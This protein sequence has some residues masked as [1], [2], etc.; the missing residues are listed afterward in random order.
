MPG[1]IVA[2]HNAEGRL[3]LAVCDADI[4][5]KK[6]ESGD[7]VLN[8]SAKFYDG[9]QKDA[10]AVEKLMMQSYTINIAGKNAVA[11]A[12]KLGLTAKEDVKTIAGVPHVQILMLN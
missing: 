3:I 9:K 7:A 6:F 12:I 11:I 4:H 8:L 2:Q 5:G 10:A 1:F